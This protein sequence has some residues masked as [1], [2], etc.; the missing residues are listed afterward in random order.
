MEYILLV[1]FNY[2]CCRSL[3]HNFQVVTTIAM[4]IFGTD[5]RGPHQN[6][7]CG[8]MKH[9]TTLQR[10]KLTSIMNVTM[11]IVT[12]TVTVI[13]I[14]TI[15]LSLPSLPLKLSPKPLP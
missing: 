9:L 4:N 1:H 2:V 7:P 15:D 14:I 6:A 5:L 3:S 10:E 12:M 11:M 13:S 8:T